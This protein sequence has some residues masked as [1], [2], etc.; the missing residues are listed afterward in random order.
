MLEILSLKIITNTIHL[1]GQNSET[2]KEEIK[3]DLQKNINEI[4]ALYDTALEIGLIQQKDIYT[5]E[6]YLE[7]IANEVQ[8]TVKQAK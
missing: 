6:T 3:K 5:L 2:E 1:S 7:E 4:V 8:I